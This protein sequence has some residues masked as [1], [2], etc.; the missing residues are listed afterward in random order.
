VSGL[1]VALGVAAGGGA[2]AA[3]RLLVDAWVTA[4]TRPGVG[5]GIVAVN[6]T[7]SFAIG[8][9]TGALADGTLRTVLV[10]GVLGGYTTFSTAS[11]DSA[12]LA[13]R[14][15]GAA[16]VAHAVG[17]AVACVAAAWL[18]LALG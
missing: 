2:G 10:T 18:G 1:L 7:G 8:V 13:L 9:A 17:T 5:W 12:R 16:A 14:G 4:R 6:V 15:R 11:L 3:L